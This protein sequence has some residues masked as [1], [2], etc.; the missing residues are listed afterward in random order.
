[1]RRSAWACPRLALG[2]RP[3]LRGE[4]PLVAP[5][6]SRLLHDD[7]ESLASARVGHMWDT[8]ENPACRSI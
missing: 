8:C 5:L 6:P 1:M 7:L 4:L 2:L 3:A